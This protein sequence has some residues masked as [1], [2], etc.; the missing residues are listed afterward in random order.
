VINEK[1]SASAS[2]L[3]R[4]S[5]AVQKDWMLRVLSE[6]FASKDECDSED[7]ESLVLTAIALLRVCAVC[8]LCPVGFKCSHGVTPSCRRVMENT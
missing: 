5:E 2:K 3:D 8:V 1:L 6:E 4:R 7:S